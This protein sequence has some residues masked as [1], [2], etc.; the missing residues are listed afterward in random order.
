VTHYDV[1]D[2]ESATATIE[3]IQAAFTKQDTSDYP[4]ISKKAEFRKFRPNLSSFFES[5]VST[6]AAGNLL[7]EDPLLETICSW[8]GSMSTSTLRQFRH[9]TTVIAL[10]II[11]NLS[12]CSAVIR[13][14]E[15]TTNRQ[16]E[17][18]REKTPQNEAR[19]QDMTAKLEKNEEKR[20]KVE[21]M[22]TGLFETVFVHRYRDIDVKIRIDCIHALSDWTQ[23]LPDMFFDG[24]YIRYLGWIL[25]DPVAATRLE[26]VKALTKLFKTKDS[27][28]NLRHFTE[29]FRPRLVEMG[30]QDVDITVRSATIEL[31]DVVRKVGF[32]EPNDIETIGRLLFDSE[33]KVRKAVVPFFVENLDDLY[34]EKLEELG[35]KDSD[36][37]FKDIEKTDSEGPTLS[38]IKLKCLVETLAAYDQADAGEDDEGQSQNLLAEK[39]SSIVMKVNE[40]VSRFSLAGAAL[41]ETLDE[42]R[43]WE[44]LARYLLYDHSASKTGGDDI[45]EENMVEKV[46]RMVALDS[47]EDV[48][49]LQIL[50]ASVTGTLV[51]GPDATNKKNPKVV[52]FSHSFL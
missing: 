14:A 7:L 15:A 37:V 33:Q 19:I 35:G 50:N 6:I 13:R 48:I 45:D 17:A 42:V 5:L 18:E 11:S 41:W 44:G 24:T 38:W 9:T 40:I 23:I 34:H 21:T 51:K 16:L 43:E 28:S 20:D 31:L 52:S 25:S 30:A 49:L 4:L 12:K 2:P 36:E 26:V 39:S 10:E 32:L 46:K 3:D 27:V 47:K 8:V 29:R 22:I 1:E